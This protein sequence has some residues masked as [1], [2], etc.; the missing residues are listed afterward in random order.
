VDAAEKLLIV[1]GV[2]NLAYGFLTGFI[3]ASIRM[4]GPESPKYLTLAHIGPLMQGPMLLALVFAVQ[5]STL[6]SS[7]ETVAAS[8]LVAGSA[9]LAVADTSNWLQGVKDAPAERPPLGTLL[10][11]GSV[12]ASTA[13]LTILIAGVFDGL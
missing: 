2:L 3:L 9:L 12:V 1:G 13:G 7:L 11:A 5:L 6:S 4:K 8:L 10:S